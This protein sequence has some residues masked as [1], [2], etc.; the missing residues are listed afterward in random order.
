MK[1]HERELQSDDIDSAKTRFDELCKIEFPIYL[2]EGLTEA[3]TRCKIID[4]ILR[5]VL[6]WPETLIKREPYVHA[7]GG[8]IDYLLST[9]HPYYVIEAKRHEHRYKLPEH[10]TRIKYKVGGVLRED[11]TLSSDM[12]QAR[13]YAISK[14][15]AFCCLTNGHQFI[16]F[17]SQNDSGIDWNEHVVVVLRDLEEV[18]RHF[19]TFFHLLSY[20]SV[21]QGI[22]HTRLPIT[23]NY[24]EA[25]RRYQKLNPAKQ[26]LGRTRERN[27]LFPAL[28]PI[29]TR[30]FQDIYNEAASS[31]ILENCYVES[32]RDSSYEKGLDGLLRRKSIDLGHRARPITVTKKDAGDFQKTVSAE[33]AKSL[34]DPE[35]LL[36]LGGI[37]VGKTTFIHRF[38]KVIAAHEI[39]DNC[40][41][42][43]VDFNKYS[44]TGEPLLEWVVKQLWESL[45]HDYHAVDLK[46][47][48]VLKQAYHSEYEH[49]RRG[50]LA[51]LFERSIEDFEIAFAR[52]LEILER[53]H[54][55]H[56]VRLI[57]VVARQTSR[58]PFLVF[59]NADQFSD[60]TQD[61]VFRLAQKFA[62]DV[63]CACAISLREESYWKNKDHGTLSAFHAISYQV[64]SPRLRPV[65][66]KR[67]K[68]ATKL[69]EEIGKDFVDSEEKILTSAEVQGVLHRLSQTLLAEDSRYMELLEHL[70]PGEVRRPL[71]F[72]SR[73]LV[74]GHT[75]MDSLLRSYRKQTNLTIGFHEFFTSIMLGDREFYSETSSDIVNLFAVDGRSDA[76]NLNR[77][78]VLG[79]TLKSKFHSTP[80]GDGFLPVAEIV[81]DCE[82]L[83]VAPDT[84]RSILALFNSKRIVETEAQN[85]NDLGTAT[86]VR[87]T[88]AGQ[89]YIDRLIS[90]FAYL[91]A[92]V[93]DTAIGDQDAYQRMKNLTDQL[94]SLQLKKSHIRLQR[95]Q[96]RLERAKHFLQY[97]AREFGNSTMRTN[98]SL[99]DPSIQK[100]FETAEGNLLRQTHE[101]EADAR[102]IFG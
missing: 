44:D 37:G 21:A 83:G 31:E 91:D 94:E 58:R 60:E 19:S 66:S 90:E 50:R 100:W 70:S 51:K 11:P 10:K 27:T 67:F 78:A 39:D 85:K 95:L 59:D 28:K 6:C 97:I 69:L 48:A 80:V 9:S 49:L 4:V 81:S 25:L 74:S 88:A 3:D 86:F 71:E 79:R 46:S 96:V 12:Q 61:Q 54:D 30:V 53:Q 14:G 22:V 15:V 87:A 23:E 98:L 26:I 8:Y 63:G 40:L 5:E 1:T 72:L 101:I 65:I 73:F 77:L 20:S 32:P 18:A 24:D 89:Y 64:Q 2:S 55:Q 57:K 47:Y 7:S 16:F 93:I 102:K 33:L 68:F 38:R 99:V 29:I 62:K 56:F 42:A 52:E 75:N 41:W 13:T 92:V 76:S 34:G 45:D 17:R 84:T 82:R 36:I 43:Y 35:V